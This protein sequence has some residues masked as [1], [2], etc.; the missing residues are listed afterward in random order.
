MSRDI[1]IANV[2][3]V[4]DGRGKRT[5]ALE[6]VNLR[7]PAGRFGS[8]IGP[9]GCGKSTLLRLI[10]D[11]LKPS[12]GSIKVGEASPADARRSYAFGFV[13]QSPTLLPWRTVSQNIELPLIIAGS[14]KGARSVGA[15]PANLISLVGLKGFENAFPHEL[16]GGMQQRAAIARALILKPDV[17]LLDEPFSALDEITRQKMNL[18]LLRIWSETGTTALL[19]THSIAEAVFMSDQV[20]MMSDR[21]GRIFDVIDILL[22]R[23]RTIEMMR[24]KVFFD[25]VNRVRDGLFGLH[26]SEDPPVATPETVNRPLDIL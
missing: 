6:N 22:N 16:S 19:V 25:C 7:L 10:G 9:S 24:S 2:S 15:S 21:P 26:T 17:L 5:A 1:L 23:P 12:S 18:E 11:I 13:F 4:F 20:Y 14:N 3:K 8:I